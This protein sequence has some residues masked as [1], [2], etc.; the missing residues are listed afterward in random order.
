M[1]LQ[2]I[3]MAGVDADWFQ[4]V[5]GGMLLLAVFVN[6]YALRRARRAAYE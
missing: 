4:V 3:V 2:G 1:V 6:T 5:L